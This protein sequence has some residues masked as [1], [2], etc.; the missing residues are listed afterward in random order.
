MALTDNENAKNRKRN[1]KRAID[2]GSNFH[3]SDTQKL[4]AV[5]SYLALGNLALTGRL[6]GIP[7]ITLRV[8]KASVW[9][10]DSVDEIRL[11]EKIQLSSRMKKL[12]EA[13]QTIVAQRLETGD[14]ILNQKTGEIVFKPVSMKDAHKV[15]VD[16]IDRQ[17]DLDK[18]TQD[19]GVSDERDDAKLEKLAE[20]FALMAT[21]SI[22]KNLNKK[23]TIEVDDA[24]YVDK[25]YESH[26]ERGTVDEETLRLSTGTTETGSSNPDD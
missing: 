23:R 9:W 11:Q 18:M 8:W 21:K 19:T 20:K 1:K 2:A 5:S 24:V 12:V 15:S 17:K 10:K 7:E 3:W 16:L 14:P 22:E 25:D 4:E 13:S 6:L 26:S